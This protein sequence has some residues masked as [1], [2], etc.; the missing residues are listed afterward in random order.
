MFNDSLP[1]TPRRLGIC[2][3]LLF[4]HPRCCGAMDLTRLATSIC[5]AAELLS[6]QPAIDVQQRE[7]LARACEK[8]SAIVEQPSSRLEKATIAVNSS[9]V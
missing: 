9:L 7:E 6:S 5:E 8:L 2:P 3:S 1:S 4:Y